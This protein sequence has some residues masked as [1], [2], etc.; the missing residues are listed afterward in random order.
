MDTGLGAL[1]GA[2]AGYFLRPLGDWFHDVRIGRKERL[3]RQ[4]DSERET[5]VAAQG[6][7]LQLERAS[8][9]AYRANPMQL[10]PLAH[11]VVQT[12]FR[13][14]QALE[15]A[16]IGM[17]MVRVRVADDKMRTL[18]AAF[19]EAAMTAAHPESADQAVPASDARR[20][21]F[22][23]ANERLGELLRGLP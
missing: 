12:L 18:L 6:S 5:L 19:E 23:A 4:A 9:A 20:A 17:K 8:A 7:M 16:V 1:L 11:P 21:A 14:D 10:Q 2:V 13:E 15:D 22:D 3:R